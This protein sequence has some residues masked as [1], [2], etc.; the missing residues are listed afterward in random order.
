[1]FMKKIIV[2]ISL[3]LLSISSLFSV[4]QTNAWIFSNEKAEIP[5]CNDSGE[6][7][8]KEW[9]DAVKNI[10]WVETERTASVYVQDVVKYALTFI[11][12]I[13]V[14]LVIYAWFNI[15]TSAGDDE[16]T[17]N[18]KKIIIYAVLWILIIYLARPIINFVL[19]LL[20]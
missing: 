18:S 12:I 4:N 14:I 5:Y 20:K 19:S 7:W 13:A 2:A 11:T 17:N 10:N 3:F 9:I 1:M 16:K 15:L 8:I 6:C